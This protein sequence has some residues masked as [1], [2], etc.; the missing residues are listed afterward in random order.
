MTIQNRHFTL[1]KN[2]AKG[3]FME[4]L[5]MFPELVDIIDCGDKYFIRKRAKF[6]QCLTFHVNKRS[7]SESFQ[8]ISQNIITFNQLDYRCRSY[9][10]ILQEKSYFPKRKLRISQFL[11]HSAFW[12]NLISNVPC[13]CNFMGFFRREYLLFAF[14]LKLHI[15]GMEK[16]LQCDLGFPTPG[17]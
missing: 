11:T 7:F 4:T 6:C 10:N 12:F 2:T 9:P 15:M 3:A 8:D 13:E 14:T 16:R 17:M 5:R 1:K